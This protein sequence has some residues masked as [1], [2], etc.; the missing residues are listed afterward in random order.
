MNLRVVMQKT[1]KWSDQVSFYRFFNHKRVTE[2]A[3]IRCATEHCAKECSGLAEVVLIEDT[4]ELNLERHRERI[5]DKEGLG[6]VGNGTDLVFFCHPTRVVN[7]ADW[8]LIG[9]ADIHC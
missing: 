8:S 5:T 1:D 9:A 6:E 2:E 7:P 3:L 4:T